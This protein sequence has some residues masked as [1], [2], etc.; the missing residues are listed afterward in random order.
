M[1]STDE[2]A[3]A[4]SAAADSGR[5]SSP[6]GH[7]AEPDLSLVSWHDADR[8]FRAVREAVVP[9]DQPLLLI[10]QVPRSGGTLLN[11]LLDGHPGL[12]VHPWELLIGHPTKYDWPRLEVD[13]DPGVWLEV[14]RERFIPRLFAEGYRKTPD[15]RHVDDMPTLPFTLAPSF[16]ERLF[17][18]LCAAEP[19]STQRAVLDR[20][21][22]AFFNAWVDCQ[23]LR[24][25][26]KSWVVG[27]CP[28]LAWGDSRR[29]FFEDYPDG[30]IVAI[31]RDPRGWYASASRLAER[32][33][34]FE[35]A[36]EFWRRG[37][38]ETLAAKKEDP[39]RTFVLTYEQLVTEPRRTMESLAGWLDID[40]D[41]ILL[42]PT[43]NR[44]PTVPNSSYRL[45][46]T[47]IR[48]ESLERWREILS[49]DDVKRIEAEALE[50]DAAVRSAS[51]VWDADT[52][53]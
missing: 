21:F 38:E 17:R 26:P 44:Q 37:A 36:L 53:T 1:A 52:S 33:G 2:P 43:F 34:E 40:W 14:L 31:H 8:V 24:E 18:V 29:R 23:G 46:E 30:A 22:T 7:L 47:G 27:F 32:Y 45:I 49:A 12:H 28:R 6:R 39:H 13:S 3:R 4:D 48:T 10:S 19:P 15:L 25:M 51:D 50:L 42:Q 11:T 16:L 20:Y 9:V 35:A 5:G 41:P